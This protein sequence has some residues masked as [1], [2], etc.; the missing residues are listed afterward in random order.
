MEKA[1]KGTNLAP[2][3]ASLLQPLHLISEVVGDLLGCEGRLPEHGG[4]LLALLGGAVGAADMGGAPPSLLWS[5]GGVEG[6]EIQTSLQS[7][8]GHRAGF[9]CKL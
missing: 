6:V 9:C 8:A 1:G 2:K 7:H 3:L 5:V 4:G